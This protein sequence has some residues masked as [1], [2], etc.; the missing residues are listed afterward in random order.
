MIEV[1]TFEGDA[2]ELAAFV[3]TTWRKWYEGRMPIPLWTS[4]FFQRELLPGDDDPRD[5]LVAAYDG[6]R[7]VGFHPARPVRISLH[8][9]EITGSRGSFLTID[10]EYRREGIARKMNAE[11]QRRHRQRG[12]VVNLGYVYVRSARSMGPKFWL[13]QPEGTMVVRKL[14]TWARAFDHAAVIRFEPYRTEAWSSRI[15]SLVQGPPKAPR[16][17]AGIR[18]YRR[19]D[20]SDCAELVR[21]RGASADLAYV[22]DLEEL[23]RLLHYRD[24]ARTV[25]FEQNGRVAGLVNYCRLEFLGK[26]PMP[27]AVIDIVAFGTLPPAARLRLLRAAMCQMADDGVKGATMLRGSWYGWRQMLAAGFFPA[28][29]DFAYVGTKMQ[30]DVPLENVRRLHVLWR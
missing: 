17:M 20:L 6:T 28:L 11:F 4:E 24:L 27:A 14:G 21:D 5:Y 12:A 9:Q 25:V 26:C 18:L 23:A 13:K 16:D 19:E 2:A 15:F 8:G 7:L 3:T 22:W 29:P 10:P 1:R 30:P